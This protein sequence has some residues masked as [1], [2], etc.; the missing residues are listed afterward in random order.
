M[1]ARDSVV[2]D[3]VFLEESEFICS[4]SSKKTYFSNVS[5]FSDSFED[6]SAVDFIRFQHYLGAIRVSTKIVESSS[7]NFIFTKNISYLFKLIEEIDYW[8]TNSYYFIDSPNINVTYFLKTLWL[9]YNVSNV[10]ISVNLNGCCAL[11]FD[12]FKN[13][14]Y[15][16]CPK[17][18]TFFD[19]LKTK[20]MCTGRKIFATGFSREQSLNFNKDGSVVGYNAKMM[21][22]ISSL[23]GCNITIKPT[24]D[25]A[26]YGYKFNGT[27]TGTFRDLMDGNAE[28]TAN[29]HFI[30]WY[31]IPELSSTHYISDEKLCVFVPKAQ[32]IPHVLAVL[33]RFDSTAFIMFSLT[34]IVVKLFISLFRHID[35]TFYNKKFIKFDFLSLYKI[36]FGIHVRNISSTDHERILLGCF[37]LMNFI[38]VCYIQSAFITAVSAPVNYKDMDTL[39][40]LRES[41]IE[42]WLSS[43]ELSS[44]FSCDKKLSG[45]NIKL[46]TTKE[47]IAGNHR[48]DIGRVT[49]LNSH[50]DPNFFE[51]IG[52]KTVNPRHIVNECLGTY[53]VSY[54]V[55]RGSSI[56]EVIDTVISRII[57][58][59]HYM[60]WITDS[61]INNKSG[62]KMINK[63]RKLQSFKSL[64]EKDI[65]VLFSCLTYG[66]FWSLI[67]FCLELIYKKCRKK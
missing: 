43:H 33:N 59:G 5:I 17:N 31:D 52:E 18:S 30:K 20:K 49:R 53:L 24:S 50:F 22:E 9:N 21:S 39:E 42:I 47:S 37:L 54:V 58:S 60:K 25:N 27:F 48:E 16:I 41:G 67:I 38:I 63:K 2:P 26:R 32:K 13:D 46:K 40:E 1:R 8:K 10:F 55:K 29:E 57:E 28:I 6:F 11:S 66:Y 56:E 4:L 3:D 65:M 12:I 15:K 36:I 44:I 34:F 35:Y 7:I 51:Y 64:T 19:T 14:I 45:L 23:I 61:A 62:L